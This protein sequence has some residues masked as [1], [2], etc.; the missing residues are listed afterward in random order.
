[1]D[2]QTIQMGNHLIKVVIMDKLTYIYDNA[3]WNIYIFKKNW[4]FGLTVADL[5]K[6]R[7]PQLTG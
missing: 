2:K 5:L 7:I 4:N 3:H 1:M 6:I